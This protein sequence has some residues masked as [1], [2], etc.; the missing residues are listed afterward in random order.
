MVGGNG[1]TVVFLEGILT[2]SNVYEKVRM[3]EIIESRKPRE[4]TDDLFDLKRFSLA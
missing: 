1:T 3:F 2:L 4:N